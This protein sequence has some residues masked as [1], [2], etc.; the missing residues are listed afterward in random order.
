[1]MRCTLATLLF[2]N[3]CQTTPVIPT[4]PWQPVRF[5]AGCWRA[6]HDDQVSLEVWTPPHGDAMYGQNRSIQDGRLEFFELLTIVQRGGKLVYIAQ[7]RGG[8]AT[9][10]SLTS[11]Q[12][13]D[14]A[15][16]LTFENPAHDFPKRIRYT[17]DAKGHLS[18]RAD[19]GTDGGKSLSFPWQ[20]VR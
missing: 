7:P 19:D 2:L 1:M 20:P 16:T 12:R 9:E 3:A 13:T 4:D 14:D 6:E 18:A 11:H 10:F 17:L 5:L 8:K 15:T